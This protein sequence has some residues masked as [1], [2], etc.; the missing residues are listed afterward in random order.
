MKGEID[1]NTIVLGDFNAPHSTIGRPSR[2][3]INKETAD[4]NN[5]MDQTDLRDIY[6]RFQPTTLEYTFFQV[7]MTYSLEQV[8]K[9]LLTNLRLK[10]QQVTFSTT[11]Q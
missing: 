10:S 1:R 4:L 6:R 8:T 7:H 9:Q 3:K 2:Q 11:V 5:T